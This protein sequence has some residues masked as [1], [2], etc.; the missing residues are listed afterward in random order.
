MRT[1]V[2]IV[3]LSISLPL[4]AQQSRPD[5]DLAKENRELKEYIERL[6]KR[7]ADLQAKADRILPF[8]PPKPYLDPY[9]PRRQAPEVLPYRWQFVPPSTR[10]AP[11]IVPAPTPAPQQPALPVPPPPGS[12]RFR[13]NGQDVFVIPLR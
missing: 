1:L 6:E 9:H 2:S 3:V 7:L 12:Y 5:K 8:A 13:F 10:P 11:R 4:Y